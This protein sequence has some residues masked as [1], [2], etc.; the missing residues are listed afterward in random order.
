MYALSP[1]KPGDNPCV[2]DRRLN[3][4]CTSARLFAGSMLSPKLLLWSLLDTDKFAGTTI[5][6]TLVMH[7]DEVS[8]A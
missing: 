7:Y 8:V 1:Q 5:S 4:T 6:W 3:P 2:D